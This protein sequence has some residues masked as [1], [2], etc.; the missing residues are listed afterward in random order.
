[1]NLAMNGKKIVLLVAILATALGVFGYSRS[2]PAITAV[3]AL[4]APRVGSAV[5]LPWPAY[6]QGA[7]AAQD[8]GI[9]Q[10][11]GEQKAVPMASVA[12]VVT[13]L[14]VLKQKPLA[15]GQQG[16]N[17]TITSDD[18]A[19]YNSY[20]T[21][22]GSVV[23]VEIGEQLTELQALQA[24]LIPSANNIADALVIWAFG[25]MD[26]Y[27]SFANKMTADMHLGSTKIADASGL[28]PNSVSSAQDLVSIGLAALKSPVIADVVSQQ[29]AELPV[30]GTVDNVN[31]LLGKDG[32]IGIKT[33][34]TTEAGG[35]FLFAAKRS[36]NSQDITLVGALMQ[37]P[38]LN[39]AI[40]DARTLTTAIDSGFESVKVISKGQ[41]VGAY[42]T[43]WGTSAEA[44]AGQD[45][46]ILAWRDGQFQANAKLTNL[47]TPAKA[48]TSVGSILATSG[49]KTVS[50][51]AVLKSSLS[52]P[53][54]T[55]RLFR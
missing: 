19:I 11:H 51:P 5:D 12:K 17:I 27:I 36:I 13:A 23:K 25:S 40:I 52:G 15:V 54:W 31:W 46:S 14:A 42:K 49:Q 33:G 6:G 38:N 30:A 16:P 8:Y 47:K 44:V 3:A 37:A 24:L 29:T 1:M 18:V 4:A 28:S 43:P 2:V 50:V 41:T 21:L 20:Y 53:S 34:N 7:L 32:V 39:T 22:G 48:S 26:S 9:L 35:C 45:L 10:T 55:W